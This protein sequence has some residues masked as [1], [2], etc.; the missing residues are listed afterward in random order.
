MNKKIQRIE[1]KSDEGELNI[2]QKIQIR[3]KS[4]II[5]WEETSFFDIINNPKN[6]EEM[7]HSTH[8]LY[9]FKEK[10]YII[11]GWKPKNN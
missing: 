1:Y 6:I 4:A 7:S 9:L 10:D 3:E 11:L 8:I 2:S 5:G